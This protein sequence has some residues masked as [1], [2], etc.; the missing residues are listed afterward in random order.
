MS[1]QNCFQKGTN[2]EPLVGI[3]DQVGPYGRL[4]AYM[5]VVSLSSQETHSS[6]R[7]IEREIIHSTR[8]NE[9]FIY[10]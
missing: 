2:D 4:D 6:S 7:I 9:T 1:C 3:Q 10:K 5:L 8:I